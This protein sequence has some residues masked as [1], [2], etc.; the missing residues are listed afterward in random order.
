MR[1]GP[2]DLYLFVSLS[3]IIVCSSFIWS[4]LSKI[5]NLFMSDPV[6]RLVNW[7]SSSVVMEPILKKN[8]QSVFV[9]FLMESQN[10]YHTLLFF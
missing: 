4:V 6:G 9:C 5:L 3:L 10:I 1:A 8:E 2:S 7:G